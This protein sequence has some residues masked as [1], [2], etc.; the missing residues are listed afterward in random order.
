MGWQE[1][2]DSNPVFFP[3]IYTLTY[4]CRQ[5]HIFVSIEDKTTLSSSH[6]SSK[7]F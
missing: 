7:P 4:S 1:D 6:F 3:F 5:L 2:E